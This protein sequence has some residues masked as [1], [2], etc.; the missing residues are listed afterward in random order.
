M[1]AHLTPWH[2]KARTMGAEHGICGVFQIM[3]R[4]VAALC[5]DLLCIVTGAVT[6]QRQ[7]QV[8]PA[9]GVADHL[10]GVAAHGGYRRKA[11]Q[12]GGLRATFR[13]VKAALHAL[14]IAHGAADILHR[15]LQPEG[16]PRL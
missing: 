16:I 7:T 1:A 3:L 11:G 13:W 6:V 15:H 2:Y 9:P 10:H 5:N 14:D 12:G 4:L 8:S